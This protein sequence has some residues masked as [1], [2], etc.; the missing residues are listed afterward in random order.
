MTLPELPK[1]AP[2]P[3]EWVSKVRRDEPHGLDVLEAHVLAYAA[4]A[5]RIA[6][7]PWWSIA[8]NITSGL[9][10]LLASIG[11]FAAVFGNPRTESRGWTDAPDVD[12]IPWASLSYSVAIVGIALIAIQWIRH[13]RRRN[14]GL[15]AVLVWTFVFGA[16][17][18]AVAF[19]L[20][21]EAGIQLGLLMLPA[22]LTMG[23]AAILF[24][25][26]QL[27]PP[28]D[29]EPERPTVS[30]EDLDERAMRHLMRVRNEALDKYW[31]RRLDPDLNVDVLKELK[32]RPLGKLHLEPYG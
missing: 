9:L 1:D 3:L 15:R 30:I 22:Y 2:G 20:A 11:G 14:A 7:T 21:G 12:A 32:T 19:A 16:L 24:L 26:I 8:W 18:A 4:E 31:S 6:K 10:A 28:P 17:G 27:S 23:L 25:L 5:D 29:P 13:G